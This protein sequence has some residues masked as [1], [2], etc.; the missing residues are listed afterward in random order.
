VQLQIDEAEK[1]AAFY[2]SDEGLRKAVAESPNPEGAYEAMRRIRDASDA[3]QRMKA[4]LGYNT[5]P[6]WGALLLE[7]I[8]GGQ[9]TEEGAR[10]LIQHLKVNSK[11]DL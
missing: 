9:I 4:E 8:A 2:R 6:E 10:R 11:G 1:R 7:L 3:L 5:S